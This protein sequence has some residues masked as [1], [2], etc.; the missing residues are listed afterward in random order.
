M[1]IHLVPGAPKIA[2]ATQA[3]LENIGVWK[4]VEES[5]SNEAIVFLP[6]LLRP[7]RLVLFSIFGT[8][9]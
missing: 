9:D 7:K 1:Q 6:T 8:E 3:G 5:F 4:T 2:S